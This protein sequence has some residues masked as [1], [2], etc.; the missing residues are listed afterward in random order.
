LK[1]SLSRS[2]SSEDRYE[3]GVTAKP[4]TN[5]EKATNSGKIPLGTI[6]EEAYFLNVFDYPPLVRQNGLFSLV[7][8]PKRLISSYSRDPVENFDDKA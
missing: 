7:G 3:D 6:L 8:F 1:I 2:L 4:T 5:S